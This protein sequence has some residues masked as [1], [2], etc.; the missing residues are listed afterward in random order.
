MIGLYCLYQ[1]DS[2]SDSSLCAQHPAINLRIYF[3]SI[4]LQSWTA[5]IVLFC[6]EVGGREKYSRA[7]WSTVQ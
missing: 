4:A 2:D 7:H 5:S 6:K 1:F 3:N